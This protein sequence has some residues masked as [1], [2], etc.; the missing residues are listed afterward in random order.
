MT[1]VAWLDEIK[2]TAEGLAPAIAQ[3]ASNGRVLMLAWQNRRALQ[4]TME[5]G[6]AVYWSRSRQRLWHKGE[7]S[8]NRQ[9]VIAVQ[10]DCDSDCLLLQVQQIGG[11]ACHTG[12]NSCFYRTLD[13]SEWQVREE[14]IQN[15]KTMYPQP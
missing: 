1:A 9:K 3:D 11:C 4:L 12:R 7:Q 8:G 2:W 15:P 5:T 13:A 14:I 6:Y 10:L